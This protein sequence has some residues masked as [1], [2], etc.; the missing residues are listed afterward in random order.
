[1]DE[2]QNLMSEKHFIY[3]KTGHHHVIR[4][5][6]IVLKKSALQELI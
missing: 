1:M 3:I 4:N 2:D 6:L 5:P